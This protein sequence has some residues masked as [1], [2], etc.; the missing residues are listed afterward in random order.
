MSI[1]QGGVEAVVMVV[2][3]GG[4]YHQLSSSLQLQQDHV[5]R[6]EARTAVMRSEVGEEEAVL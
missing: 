4:R 6:D 1:I 5:T 3:G 2:P